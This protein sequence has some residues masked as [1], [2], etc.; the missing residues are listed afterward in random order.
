MKDKGRGN[1]ER[2]SVKRKDEKVKRIGRIG[3][4]GGRGK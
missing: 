4:G 3:I 2:E 1:D